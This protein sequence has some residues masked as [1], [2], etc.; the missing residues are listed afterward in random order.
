MPS[1]TA[2]QRSSTEAEPRRGPSRSGPR[3]GEIA[4]SGIRAGQGR[5]EK[6]RFKRVQQFE[7]AQAKPDEHVRRDCGEGLAPLQSTS[8]FKSSTALCSTRHQANHT[9]HLTPLLAVEAGEQPAIGAIRFST[10]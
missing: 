6:A 2:M 5:A 8:P 1:Q 10:G 4:A 3:W 7:Q 9:H